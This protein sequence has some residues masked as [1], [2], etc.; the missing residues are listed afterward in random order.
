MEG[1]NSEE[2]KRITEELTQAS[3]KIAEAM[4][5]KASQQQQ[6]QGAGG[7][8]AGEASGAKEE[9]VVDADFEEVQK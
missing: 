5:A 8:G 4:Y 3:H 7:A 2:I 1:E 9:D 6:G